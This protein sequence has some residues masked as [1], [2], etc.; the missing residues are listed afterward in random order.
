MWRAYFGVIIGIVLAVGSIIGLVEVKSIKKNGA[1]TYARVSKIRRSWNGRYGFTYY[2]LLRYRVK[3]NSYE[4]EISVGR[5]KGSHKVGETLKIMYHRENPKKMF[6]DDGKNHVA[7]TAFVFLLAIG[8][9]ALGIF[10]IIY[11][12]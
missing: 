11:N 3:G 8:L 9:T 2:A 7:F 1:H 6:V 10:S 5:F 12:L 4:R